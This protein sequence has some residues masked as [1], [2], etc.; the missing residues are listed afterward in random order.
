MALKNIYSMIDRQETNIINLL[1]KYSGAQQINL[2]NVSLT[3][4]K[5]KPIQSQTQTIEVV[6]IPNSLRRQERPETRFSLL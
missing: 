2:H 1:N 6:T 4:D 3:E 5:K